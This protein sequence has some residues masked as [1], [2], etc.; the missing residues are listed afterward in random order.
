MAIEDLLLKCVGFP[1]VIG[2][3]AAIVCAV[4]IS[5]RPFVII[6]FAILGILIGLGISFH[7]GWII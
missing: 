6:L 5:K 7:F 3:I 4:W 1:A 2:F